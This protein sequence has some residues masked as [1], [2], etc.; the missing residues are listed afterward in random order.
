MWW[1]LAALVATGGDGSMA[2]G[3]RSAAAAVPGGVALRRRRDRDRCV[4]ERAELALH[5]DWV[6]SLGGRLRLVVGSLVFVCAV[7]L[8][9]R[10]HASRS[11]RR[12]AAAALPWFAGGLLTQAVLRGVDLVP[13]A[14]QYLSGNHLSALI[15][16]TFVFALGLRMTARRRLICCALLLIGLVATGSRWGIWTGLVFGTFMVVTIYEVAVRRL[17]SIGLVSIIAFPGVMWSQVDYYKGG[18]FRALSGL[19]FVRPWTGLGPGGAE[20]L[21]LQ[22]VE[23]TSRLTHIESLPLDW[24]ATM[25]WPV[26]LALIFSLIVLSLSSGRAAPTDRSGDR[27]SWLAAVGII[28]LLAHDLFDFAIASGALTV[29]S[30]SWWGWAE[31]CARPIARWIQRLSL[32]ALFSPV[33]LRRTT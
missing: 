25:G 3:P 22:F 4:T 14:F 7:G 21:S 9:A 26:A 11:L 2:L 24:S 5:G 6:G 17:A 15:S 8:G 23:R 10:L 13:E 18:L 1:L 30:A 20:H 28:G 29:C 27:L 19:S 33:W 12:D 31:W 16:A 32:R